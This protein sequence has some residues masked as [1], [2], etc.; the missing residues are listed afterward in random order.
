MCVYT[1]TLRY[2]LLKDVLSEQPLVTFVSSIF[3]CITLPWILYSTSLSKV[4][5][6]FVF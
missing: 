3:L 6:L 2:H 4:V 5:Y 1:H